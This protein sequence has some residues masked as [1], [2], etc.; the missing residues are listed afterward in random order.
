LTKKHT[1]SPSSP[2]FAEDLEWFAGVCH[3]VKGLRGAR[4]GQIGARTTPFNTTRYSEKLLEQYGIS[5]ET[6]DLSEVLGRVERLANDDTQVQEKLVAIKA[7]VSTTGIKE[8]ALL[9]MARLGVV[10]DRWM[11]ENELVANA[12]QCW[13]A[14]ENYFG[15]VPC[16]LMSMLSNNLIPS[17]CETDIPGVIGMYALQ[18]ASGLPSALVDWNNNYGDDPNKAVVFHCSNLPKSIFNEAK[19]DYQEILAGDV[20]KEN[21]YGTIVGRIK[22]SPFTYCRVS[23][24]DINGLITTYVGEGDFTNDT[25]LTFGGYGVVSIPNLQNLLRY[26]CENGFEH[27]VAVNNARVARILEEALGNYLGW[28][29]YHHK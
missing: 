13:T 7:Y 20:G 23:T 17:A 18:L 5:V 28:E 29:V 24:D 8:E 3:V 22:T 2:E 1:L 16:A 15:V 21:A 9:K 26:I 10:I 27:H 6:L 4:F 25:L 12:I 11:Q 19:M 14:L